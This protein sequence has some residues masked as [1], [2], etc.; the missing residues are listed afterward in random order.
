[1][2][3]SEIEAAIE[4]TLREMIDICAGAIRSNIIW[5]RGWWVWLALNV[6]ALA[7]SLSQGWWAPAAVNVVVVGLCAFM[8]HYHTRQLAWWDEQLA[9]DTAE[10]VHHRASV[11]MRQRG[12]EL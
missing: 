12:G 2:N 3:E 8:I 1:M 5:R 6:G 11:A 10:L 7:W 9:K 4:E